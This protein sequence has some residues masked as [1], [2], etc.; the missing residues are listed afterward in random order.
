[1]KYTYY[2]RAE[3][4]NKCNQWIHALK[5]LQKENIN[6]EYLDEHDRRI[7]MSLIKKNK[8]ISQIAKDLNLKERLIQVYI[9]FEKEK[10]KK[11]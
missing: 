10:K 3:T 6:I 2:L 8:T 9:D 5:S 7:I 4:N 11:H 1:M